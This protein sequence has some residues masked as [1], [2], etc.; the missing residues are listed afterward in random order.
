MNKTNIYQRVLDKFYR[1]I[2]TEHHDRFKNNR[3][4][5]C[6]FAVNGLYP[7]I[8]LTERETK[9]IEFIIDIA[10]EDDINNRDSL[11]KWKQLSQNGVSFWIIVPKNR[12]NL[13]E[14]W[15]LKEKIKVLFGTYEVK[16]TDVKIKLN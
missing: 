16:E 6:L 12:L 4:G 7:D 5:E 2:N 10:I 8:I 3:F 1:G 9:I 15:A 14:T 13:F 11:D